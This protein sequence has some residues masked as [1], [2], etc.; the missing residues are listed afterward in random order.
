MRCSVN[1][2]RL[3]VSQGLDFGRGSFGESE[4]NDPSLPAMLDHRSSN[5]LV[6]CIAGS[7]AYGLS[8][9][10]SDVDLR[11]VYAL[12]GSRYLA[13]EPAPAQI[14]DE[15]HNQ[16]YYSLRR[17]LELLSVGNPNMIEL[18]YTPPDCIRYQSPL[19]SVLTA[20]RG[21]MICRRSVESLIG[22]AQGQ[23]KKA[24]G[25]NKWINQAQPEAAPVPEDHCY[26]LPT[27]R[28]EDQGP[29]CR[30]LSLGQSQI[31][32]DQH[33]AARVEHSHE[34]YRLYF[35]GND[36][37]GVFR[38]GQLVCESIPI[39]QERPRF[40]GLL[41]FNRQGYERARQDHQN[42]WTWRR[43]RNE[44]RWRQQEAGELDYDAKNLM[45]TL[46]LLL[47]AQRMTIDGEP[48]IRVEGAQREYLL[49]VRQ[50][51]YSYDELRGQAEEL[52]VQCRAQLLS[53]ALPAE[54]PIDLCES[55]LHELTAAW[56]ERCP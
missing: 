27:S 24:R 35:Y 49:A 34:L 53:T 54:A 20:R 25:Q 8:H 36:A 23:I 5:L 44:E 4:V 29:P 50:G 32:L 42:Y 56:E 48:L 51:H 26:F 38:A 1:H 22:Y 10:D 41:L 11:G 19:W 14:H 43:E 16:V 33:H 28:A 45:H 31:A 40:V 21:S 17:F 39:D 2:T 46:L 7:R 6:E 52:V 13:L 30:P 55:L 15:R 3:I 12:P 37:R 9:Q 18:L 47:S